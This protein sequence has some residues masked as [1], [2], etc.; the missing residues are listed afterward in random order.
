MSTSEP[1]R[2]NINSWMFKFDDATLT[3]GSPHIV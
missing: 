2:N 1:D 3:I